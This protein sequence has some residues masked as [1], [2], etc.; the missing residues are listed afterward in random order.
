MSFNRLRY[1][2]NGARALGDNITAREYEATRREAMK[3]NADCSVNVELD[4]LDVNDVEM[5]EV[6]IDDYIRRTYVPMTHAPCED[7]MYDPMYEAMY[8]VIYK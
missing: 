2:K 4:V 7:P 8:Q 5:D 3:T 1:R 6:W